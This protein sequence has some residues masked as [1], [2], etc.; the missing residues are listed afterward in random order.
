MHPL[1]HTPT[2]TFTYTAGQTG[3]TDELRSRSGKRIDLRFSVAEAVLRRLLIDLSERAVSGCC[4]VR[5][6]HACLSACVAV[7]RLETSTCNKAE[8]K[9]F[10]AY[11]CQQLCAQRL[12]Q[13]YA[14]PVLSS[15]ISMHTARHAQRDMHK[16][17]HSKSQHS[18]IR[19]QIH[20]HKR[21]YSQT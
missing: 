14:T 11:A 1:T 3:S 9:L 10:A 7:T 19:Q 17:A 16:E 18:Y 2:H 20:T 12:I 15:P 5:S 4:C 8:T 21:A 13:Y 6:I